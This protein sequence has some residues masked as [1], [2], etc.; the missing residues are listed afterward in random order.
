VPQFKTM[1]RP[2]VT[3]FTRFT[4]V[5]GTARIDEATRV[6]PGSAADGLLLLISP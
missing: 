2:E 4:P 5:A 1:S 6:L 3:P